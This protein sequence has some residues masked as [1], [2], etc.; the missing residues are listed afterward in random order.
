[1]AER[2]NGNPLFLEECV[3]SLV[4]TGAL[5]GEPGAYRFTRPTLALE[6][7]PTVRATIASRIDRLRYEDKRLL[8]AASVIGKD[9]RFA[10]LE[11]IAEAPN[12]ELRAGLG[13]LQAAEFLYETRLY[14]DLEFTFKHALTH[15]VAYGSMLHERQRALHTR[16]VVA[17]ERL[18][19]DRLA[20]HLEALAH[21]ALRG[22][23]WEKALAYIRQAG[24]K[25]LARS[26]NREAVIWF[27]QALGALGRLP[28]NREVLEQAIDLR[29]EL[30]GALVYLGEHERDLRYLAEARTIAERL[31]DRRPRQPDE[32]LLAHRGPRARARVG[33]GGAG[34]GRGRRRLRPPDPSEPRPR[35]GM[36][37]SRRSPAGDGFPQ[38]E[39]GGPLG[40]YAPRSNGRDRT[41]RGLVSRLAVPMPRGSRRVRSCVPS[42]RTL[43]GS[44]G[45]ISLP[46]PAPG[47]SPCER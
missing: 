27:E 13:R 42:Q 22:E 25:A 44:T 14:P 6:V 24:D 5:E 11:A 33:P 36:F 39:R 1:V 4:D 21:H 23:L 31:G 12:G 32:P 15:E 10:L 17:I 34:G 2:A 19:A 47:R 43:R 7:P 9:V 30:H 3:A 29:L 46:R 38:G 28:E 41:P 26:A 40:R 35:S 18:H 45:I 8:Q 20:E 37:R 16:I